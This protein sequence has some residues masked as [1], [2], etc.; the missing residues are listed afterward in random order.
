[1][2]LLHTT[3]FP[4]LN[5][6]LLLAVLVVFGTGLRFWLSLVQELK[7][8][9]LKMNGME[10]ALQEIHALM[11]RRFDGLK[12]EVTRLE[13]LNATLTEQVTS[14]SAMR[15]AQESD[16]HDGPTL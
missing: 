7:V 4:V 2:D 10:V 15:L 9:G 12:T 11:Q 14:L 3:V 8:V 1:M 6:G 13:A 16:P 5:F